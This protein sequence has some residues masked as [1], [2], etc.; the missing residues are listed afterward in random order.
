MP[1]GY[2]NKFDDRKALINWWLTPLTLPQSNLLL[3]PSRRV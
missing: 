3:L 1:H 2:Q